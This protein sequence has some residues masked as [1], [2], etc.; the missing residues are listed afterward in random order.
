MTKTGGLLTSSNFQVFHEMKDGK[1]KGRVVLD[2][3]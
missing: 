1:L 2:L 3:Q